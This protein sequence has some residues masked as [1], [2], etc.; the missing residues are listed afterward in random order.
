M[1]LI[2][3]YI[4]PSYVLQV[5]DQLLVDIREPAS[6][7]PLPDLAV[8]SVVFNGRVVFGYTGL[9]SLP[10]SQL[11]QRVREQPDEIVPAN[12]WLAH[13][14]GSEDGRRV[15]DRVGDEAAE[16]MGRLRRVR[17]QFRRQAFIG[18]G[19]MNE[20]EGLRPAVLK[21]TNLD[22]GGS[23]KRSLEFLGPAQGAYLDTTRSLDS[24]AIKPFKRQI[25][26]CIN[27]R[28]GPAS[29]SRLLIEIARAVARVD[30]TVGEDLLLTCLP[31]GQVERGFEGE[32]WVVVQGEPSESGVSF[33]HVP[34]DGYTGEP[35]SPSWVL[36]GTVIEQMRVEDSA[37][38]MVQ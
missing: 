22:S 1:S 28:L 7:V 33:K 20:P 21:V 6:P 18:V 3:S 19:W 5:S 29:V 34:A 30:Q 9:A 26:E 4:S 31:R 23:F 17:K 10:S 25:Q 37:T 24:P 15:L 2:L 11:A 27:R 14:L 16:S 38:L 32:G 35:Y 36:G 13:V 8:K 12:E